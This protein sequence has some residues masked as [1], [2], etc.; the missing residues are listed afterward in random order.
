MNQNRSSRSPGRWPSAACPPRTTST[1]TYWT[2]C[3]HWAASETKTNF[4]RICSQIGEWVDGHKGGSGKRWDRWNGKRKI[5]KRSRE[6]MERR[7]GEWKG[8]SERRRENNVGW[9]RK[10]K[11]RLNWGGGGRG[12]E[13]VGGEDMAARCSNKRRERT[14]VWRSCALGSYEIPWSCHFGCQKP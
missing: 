14:G 9:R 3:I 13:Q 10:W 6:R 1:R 4:W 12:S 11:S 8:T 5:R 2:A 7:R